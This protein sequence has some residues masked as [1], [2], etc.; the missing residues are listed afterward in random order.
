MFSAVGT[1]CT[2]ILISSRLSPK[3]SR[4]G[5]RSTRCWGDQ[6]ICKVKP[7]AWASRAVIFTSQLAR[8]RYGR[9]S[10]WDPGWRSNR[11]VTAR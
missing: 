4:F 6:A 7:T 9:V 5:R 1:L 2:F 10:R 3:T 8:S 11:R